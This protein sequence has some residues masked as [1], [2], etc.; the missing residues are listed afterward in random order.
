MPSR[1]GLCRAGDAY[2]PL[3]VRL[4]RLHVI[5]LRRVLRG[6][7]ALAG[8]ALTLGLTLRVGTPGW[9]GPWSGASGLATLYA[10]ETPP[11]ATPG[12]FGEITLLVVPRASSLAAL[13]YRDGLV[14]GRFDGGPLTLVVHT[15]DVLAVRVG[16]G[17]Q[18]GTVRVLAASARLRRPDAGQWRIEPGSGVSLPVVQVG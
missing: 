17:G 1:A 7:A 3:V 13:L 5:S 16:A 9:D 11:A 10:Q 18:P 2:P 8:V 12:R 14:A 4:L 6:A 15:G